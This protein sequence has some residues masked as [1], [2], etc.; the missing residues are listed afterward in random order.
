MEGSGF[1]AGGKGYGDGQ[2]SLAVCGSAVGGE[3]HFVG[4][5]VR[6]VGEEIALGED[7]V[8][9]FT[10]G[11][12]RMLVAEV[13]AGY[14]VLITPEQSGGCVGVISVDTVHSGEFPV[15]GLL[16]EL[17]TAA[18]VDEYGIMTQC[19]FQ[20]I[21]AGGADRANHTQ[22]GDIVVDAQH[23]GDAAL[24][25]NLIDDVGLTVALLGLSHLDVVEH[26]G[27][28]LPVHQRLFGGQTRQGIGGAGGDGLGRLHR[29]GRRFRNGGCLRLCGGFRYRG[30][31][32]RRC[33]RRFGN[34]RCD[35]CIRCVGLCGSSAAGTQH[36]CQ[37]NQKQAKQSLHIDSAPLI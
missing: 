33:G 12:Q 21:Q 6:V 4:I 32:L 1:A 7:R 25:Q 18:C 9:L 11:D 36:Q 5:A 23:S 31:R 24:G 37:R 14:A 30:S 17:G 27:H 3:G 16:I 26:D 29:C 20:I 2:C 19:Q 34:G 22:L 13:L 35:R 10:G 28:R 8:E 15:A